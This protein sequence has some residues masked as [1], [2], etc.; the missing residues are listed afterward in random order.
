MS[1]RVGLS[2]SP[3]S[4]LWSFLVTAKNASPPR[5]T[6]QRAST[7]TSRRS[8]TSRLRISATPPPTAVEL[9][10]CSAR[11]RRR[12]PR[13]RSSSMVAAPTRGRTR[14]GWPSWLEPG[15]QALRDHPGQPVAEAVRGVRVGVEPAYR[16]RQLPLTELALEPAGEVV[17]LAPVAQPGFEQVIGDGGA[18]HHTQRLRE[19]AQAGGP[20]AGREHEGDRIH[21]VEL[22]A[23]RRRTQRLARLEIAFDDGHDPVAQLTEVVEAYC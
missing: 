2:G 7:P 23:G 9:M 13:R 10:F 8:G 20:M 21:E 5:I 1:S 4:A 16:R 15:P 12:S 6:S 22:L 3:C 18:A 17:L 11:P 14:R 19:L